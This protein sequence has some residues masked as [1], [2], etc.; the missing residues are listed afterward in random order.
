MVAKKPSAFYFVSHMGTCNFH[1]KFYLLKRRITLTFILYLALL[2]FCEAQAI[3][4]PVAAS[5][6][7]IGAY[8]KRHQDVFSFTSN[9]AALAQVNHAVAGVFGERRFMLN[10]L[11]NYVAALALPT[12]SGN[13]GLKTGYYGFSDY[14]E[15]QIGL[16]YGRKMGEKV[17]IGAQFNYNAIRISGYGSSSAVSFEIGTVL[18]I[19]EQIHA[20]IHINNPV[21]GKFGKDQQEKLPSVYSLGL[22][23]DAS[24]KFFFSTEIMKE[25]DQPVN[26]IAGVQYKLLPQL[27][28]RAGIES[29]TSSAYAGIGLFWKN[30]RLDV[31]AAFHPQLGVS[32]GLLMIIQFNQQNN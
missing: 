26:V 8:S 13:F 20:G 15:T 31:T 27:L 24:E 2:S 7:G 22:G 6:I 29:A 5:Y 23:Y 28:T 18:H 4:S 17:D 1:K 25:E 3:R 19:T 21:G 11:N 16:A 32:P 12:T 9:Q 30:F 14:N 10:E